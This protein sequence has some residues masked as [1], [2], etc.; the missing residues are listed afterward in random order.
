MATTDQISK[1]G[2]AASFIERAKLTQRS[3]LEA[4]PESFL[5][6]RELDLQKAII[7]AITPIVEK[8]VSEEVKK[9][10]KFMDSFQVVSE[11]TIKRNKDKQPTS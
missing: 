4:S 3:F 5:T 6:E 8:I 2:Q 10:E 11:R 7:E 9:A 1:L